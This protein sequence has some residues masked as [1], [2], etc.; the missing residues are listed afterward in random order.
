MYVALR[1]TWPV[2]LDNDEIILGII[3]LFTFKEKHQVL[4]LSYK[5]CKMCTGWNKKG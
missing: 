1:Q 2:V 3:N 5:M 4:L